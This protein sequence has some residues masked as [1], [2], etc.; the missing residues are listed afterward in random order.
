MKQNRVLDVDSYKLSHW[1]MYPKKTKGMFAY[2]EA[3]SKGDTIVP[4]G[5]QMWIKKTLLTPITMGEVNEAETFSALHG[6]PFNKEDW[7][8]LI[9]QHKG[10][11]PVTIRSV[12]EGTR[13]PSDT[14]IVTIESNDERLFWMV[15]YLE[16][17]LQR[18]VWYPTTVASNDYK[19]WCLIKSYLEATADTLDM[20]PFML[21]DFGARGVSSEE[22]AQIG[23]AAH[24][25]YFQGSDNISGI[26]AANHYYSCKSCM[27][28]YSVPATEHSIQCAY[29]HNMY[30]Q[31]EYLTNVL[32]TSGPSKI[33][34]IVIDGYDTFRECR[35]LCHTLKD[36]VIETGC[37]VVFR[38]D[39][40]KPLT[41]TEEILD[42][43]NQTFGSTLN[44]KGYKV[45]NNVGIIWGDGVNLEVM[46][47]LLELVKAKGF[48][49]ENI[50]FGSGGALLQK[51]DR[52]TYSFAQ[53]SS[54]IYDGE[55]WIPIFKDP[56]TQPNKKSKSGLLDVVGGDI[57]YE[58]GN[59]F[60]QTTLD[61]IRERAQV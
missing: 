60:N 29:G 24:L 12:K 49:A 48:S 26:R 51:V 14:V 25:V 43:Q 46:R 61:S 7:V 44:S 19:A 8:Y 22:S 6:L 34:S 50:V 23:G 39:S 18:A 30:D 42:L 54:A 45:L 4:F 10:Y 58:N 40:G 33:I 5:I 16:T 41:V 20:L 11:I 56:I 15:S 37:K 52:D 28:G 17:S 55:K 1:K 3:R 31:V 2:I 36:K 13:V 32:E 59:L 9:E 53:K 57:V 47:N 35:T 21:H 27:A 38:P